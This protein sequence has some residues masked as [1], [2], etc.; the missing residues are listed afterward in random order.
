MLRLNAAAAS[1]MSPVKEKLPK[2]PSVRPGTTL[3]GRVS[4]VPVEPF[5]P[6]TRIAD[7]APKPVDAVVQ[8]P[9]ADPEGVIELDVRRLAIR[10]FLRNL[11]QQPLRQVHVPNLDIRVPV[12]A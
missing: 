12:P 5:A 3:N 1:L 8:H 9:V 4:V 6:G 11:R 7:L 10:G 2:A